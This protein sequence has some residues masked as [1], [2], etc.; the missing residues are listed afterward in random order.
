M[1]DTTISICLTMMC[2]MGMTAFISLHLTSLSR[3]NSRARRMN[4][5]VR[6]SVFVTTSSRD[7]FM[8]DHRSYTKG[9]ENTSC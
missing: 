6:N 2:F 8:P 4:H 5:C 3:I 7:C 9:K 1:N